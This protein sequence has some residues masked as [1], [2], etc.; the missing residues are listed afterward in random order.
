MLIAIQIIARWQAGFFSETR[1]KPKQEGSE[2]T[3]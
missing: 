3:L 2:E 1:Q